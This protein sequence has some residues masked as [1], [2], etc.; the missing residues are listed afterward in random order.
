MSQKHITRKR[1]EIDDILLEQDNTSP[2]TSAA[3][4]DAIAC[5]EFTVLPYPAYSLY[6]APINFHLFPTLKVDLRGQNLNS[7]E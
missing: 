1:A 4:T 6:L 7:D 2:C 5:L 3:T